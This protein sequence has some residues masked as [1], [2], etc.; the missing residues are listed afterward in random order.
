MD[1]AHEQTDKA[2]GRLER[3]INSVYSQ[4]GKDLTETLSAY[5]RRFEAQ[6]EAKL[7]QVD[8]G[9]ITREEYERWRA[10]TIPRGK[11][12][13]EAIEN[14]ARIA[15][16]ANKAAMEVITGRLRNSISHKTE[17]DAVYVGAPVEY[18]PFVELG[19]PYLKP[20]VADHAEEYKQIAKAMMENA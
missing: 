17:S 13:E 5:M 18:A 19:L 9:Q 15:N 16:N 2:I 7:K 4:V 1:Y 20:A 11:Q 12:Y 6:D 3:A 8:A 10:V 14:A